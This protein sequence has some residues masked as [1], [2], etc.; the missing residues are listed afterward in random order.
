MR[1]DYEGQTY[2]FEMN[3]IKIRQAIKIEKYLGCPISEF[4]E[5]LSPSDGKPP[6]LMAM[7]CLGWLILHE[8]RG[9]PIEDTDFSVERFTIAL[10]KAA[11]AEQAAEKAAADSAA[12]RPV[13]TAAAEPHSANGAAAANAVLTVP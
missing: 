13:P 10:T 4:G 6:D 5:R 8:G 2:E 7:Q 12:A 1:I 9:V 3:D 11:E